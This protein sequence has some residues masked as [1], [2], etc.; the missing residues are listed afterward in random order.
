[1][2]NSWHDDR[3]SLRRWALIGDKKLLNI[4]KER[5]KPLLQSSFGLL[6]FRRNVSRILQSL[7]DK[8]ED[9]AVLL[10]TISS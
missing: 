7:S 6:Y 1:M 10:V 2:R 9:T 8:R 5:E 4:V 3:A